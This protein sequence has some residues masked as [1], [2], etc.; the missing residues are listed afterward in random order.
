MTYTLYVIIVKIFLNQSTFFFIMEYDP[1]NYNYDQYA[2]TRSYIVFI[3]RVYYIWPIN[4]NRTFVI[5]IIFLL[6]NIFKIW[7]RV[8]NQQPFIDKKTYYWSW[9]F[10]DFLQ[11]KV[12]LEGMGHSSLFLHPTIEKLD[13]F[14]TNILKMNFIKQLIKT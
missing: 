3:F 10:F 8:W 11:L 5:L 2:P 13:E 4:I 1:I 14:Y 12:N 9:I 6:S 7:F